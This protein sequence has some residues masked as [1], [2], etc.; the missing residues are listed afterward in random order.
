MWSMPQL[1]Q[2]RSDIADAEI[3]NPQ[4]QSNANIDPGRYDWGWG[5][6][7]RDSFNSFAIVDRPNTQVP[8]QRLQV[9]TPG[10]Y[11]VGITGNISTNPATTGRIVLTVRSGY[12]PR[13]WDQADEGGTTFATITQGAANT[14]FT[15]APQR[16]YLEN[17]IGLVY[18]VNGG[19]IEFR[20]CN[21]IMTITT[22][23]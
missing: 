9:I 22:A 6:I 5:T 1:H 18:Y 13:T 20:A 8:F 23:W 7:L 3:E 15:V 11:T 19:P 10:Y 21:V 4:S 14:T 12:Q 2:D 17:Y 16:V